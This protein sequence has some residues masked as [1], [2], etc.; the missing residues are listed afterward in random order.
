MASMLSTIG[1]LS[2]FQLTVA[3][4]PVQEH[5]SPQHHPS[6]QHLEVP[7]H[8]CSSSLCSSNSWRVPKRFP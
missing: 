3:N 7:S 4:P 8:T 5:P 6:F 1:S 2:A